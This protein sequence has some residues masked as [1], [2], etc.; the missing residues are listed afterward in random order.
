MARLSAAYRSRGFSSEG[1]LP[2][3]LGVVLRYLSV[4]GGDEEGD[5][6]LALAVLP[7]VASVTGELERQAHPWSPLLGAL[8]L[9]V[10]ARAG[11]RGVEASAGLPAF[12]RRAESGGELR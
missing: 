10:R 12:A 2:D 4:H 11:D 7:A 3:H 5:D 6:L 8:L 9:A 1:E